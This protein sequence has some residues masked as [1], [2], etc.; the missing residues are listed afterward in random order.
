[1]DTRLF[2]D[3]LLYCE[4]KHKPFSAAKYIYTHSYYFPLRFGSY[5]MELHLH[6]PFSLPL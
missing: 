6:I 2:Q 3:E 4:N 5:T 1:M